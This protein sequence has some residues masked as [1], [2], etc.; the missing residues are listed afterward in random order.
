METHEPRTRR[1]RSPRS[2]SPSTRRLRGTLLAL[3]LAGGLLLTG[4]SAGGGGGGSTSGYDGEQS[5][6]GKSGVLPAPMPDGDASGG[7]GEQ[8]GG[9]SR[10]IA[11]SP[12][13]LS[14]FALDVDTDWYC[15]ARRTLAEGNTPDPSTIRPEEFVNSFRQDCRRPDGN[16]FS[17]TVDG[18]RTA[19]ADADSGDWSLVRIGLAT[20]PTEDED[21]DERPHA[22]LTFV[23]DVSGSMGEPGRLDLV[24]DALDVMTR[25]LRDDDSVA[26]VTFSD[27]AE[28]GGGPGRT[29]AGTRAGVR[30]AAVGS[31][32]AHRRQRPH[33]PLPMERVQPVPVRRPHRGHPQ[34]RCARRPVPQ[35]LGVPQRGQQ[36]RG[37]PVELRPHLLGEIRPLG[38]PLLGVGVPAGVQAALHQ[39]VGLDLV[40]EDRG[41]G[42]RIEAE[43]DGSRGD[44]VQDLPLAR[45]IVDGLVGAVLGGGH[46]VGQQQPLGEQFGE[47][48]EPGCDGGRAYGS[49]RHR[50]G[51]GGAGEGDGRRGADGDEGGVEELGAHES[52][53]SVGGGGRRR[54]VAPRRA[55]MYRPRTRRV[56]PGPARTSPFRMGGNY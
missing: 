35:G 3:G 52:F 18:A 44:V 55:A 17:V 26:I 48:R 11:P 25:R 12:D 23:I 37:D 49:R 19:D 21:E 16:G 39:L 24:R 38:R 9:T 5:R 47:R 33:Q 14:T 41:H 28:T 8:Q 54:A 15:H 51:R 22:A 1:T 29:D 30:P 27:D 50:G 10:G 7:T 31:A 40:A 42:V 32:L 34:P 43:T 45:R 4:C 13:Y 20:R 56:T 2:R 36:F 53:P 46:L 6:G